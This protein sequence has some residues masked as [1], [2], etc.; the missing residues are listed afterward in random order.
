[1]STEGSETL[2]F[3]G[4]AES[5]FCSGSLGWLPVAEV[6]TFFVGGGLEVMTTSGRSLLSESLRLWEFE[7]RLLMVVNEVESLFVRDGRRGV[8]SL[9]L[10]A[11][12]VPSEEPEG[13][14]LDGGRVSL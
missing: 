11:L 2:A 14:F 8:F 7:L 10:D 3:L 13:S 1:M 4:G 5:A 9:R 6:L 12:G